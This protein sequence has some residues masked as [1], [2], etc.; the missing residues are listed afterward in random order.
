M[1]TESRALSGSGQPKR[2][3]YRIVVATT[4]VLVL[5]CL[6][7]SVLPSVDSH[8]AS[9]RTQCRNNLKQIGLALHDYH[10][11]HGCFP[12]AYTQDENGRRLHSW[13]T[14]ILP[15]MDH[16]RLFEQVDLSKP[17]DHPANR[18]VRKQCPAAYRCPKAELAAGQTS[19]KVVVGKDTVFPRN[20]QTRS[21]DDIADGTS[22]TVCV[23]ETTAD[24]AVHW[25]NPRGDDALEF[26][27]VLPDSP[28]LAHTNA[29]FVDGSVDSLTSPTHTNVLAALTTISG[30]EELDYADWE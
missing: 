3:G 4:G 13:R 21:I 6:C 11:E 9:M 24:H 29:L 19:Y 23:V 16:G 2:Y 5:L 30:G 26:L 15:Y 17:W 20:G 27:S 10:D 8:P 25:M 22:F 14:L 28:D 12:P 18:E 1:E 7:L